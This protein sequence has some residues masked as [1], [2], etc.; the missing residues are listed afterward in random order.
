MN[1]LNQVVLEGNVCFDPELKKTTGG[2]SVCS[3]TIAVSRAYK[4]SNGE[5]IEEVSFVEIETFGKLAENCVKYCPKGRLIQIIGR[6]KQ[7]RWEDNEGN[8][9]S[10]IRVIAEHI[11]F[12]N[13][14]KPKDS[15]TKNVA[16]I[17]E[18]ALA[19]VKEL[20]S[21]NDEELVF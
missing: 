4:N 5:T 10:K 3:I 12:R 13:M 8:K 6:L 2:T 14:P 11:E 19:A 7:D 21:T 18:T 16:M 17:S 15:N 9:H 1:L 20:D